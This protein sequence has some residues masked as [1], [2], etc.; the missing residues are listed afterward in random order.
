MNSD[1]FE[2]EAVAVNS[3]EVIFKEP[4]VLIGYFITLFAISTELTLFTLVII[5]ISAAGIVFIKKDYKK[6]PP[7]RRLQLEDCSPSSMKL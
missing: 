4:S 7:Q 1:V 2:I 6:K 3:I 5:P